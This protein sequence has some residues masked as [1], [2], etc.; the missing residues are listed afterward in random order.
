MDSNKIFHSLISYI[1]MLQAVLPNTS[2]FK[3]MEIDEDARCLLMG[4]S[5]LAL[6]KMIQRQ[7]LPMPYCGSW[8]LPSL[9]GWMEK[10]CYD[11]LATLRLRLTQYEMMYKII[12]R[13]YYNSL[14]VEGLKH[15]DF[16]LICNTGDRQFPTTEMDVAKDCETLGAGAICT[17]E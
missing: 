14:G 17:M 9:C 10:R 12:V 4:I 1:S 7:D 13:V 2:Q 11:E 8:E 3:E 15:S 5:P 16:S 6:G